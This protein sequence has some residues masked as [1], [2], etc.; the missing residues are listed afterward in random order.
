MNGKKQRSESDEIEQRLRI[1]ALELQLRSY[2]R[3]LSKSHSWREWLTAAAPA[4]AFVGLA[5]TVSWAIIQNNQA[6]RLRIE[7]DRAQRFEAAVNRLGSHDAN[8][9]LTG[10]TG[11]ET[12][13][14]DARFHATAWNS[15][16][17]AIAVED[18]AVVRASLLESIHSLPASQEMKNDGL[19]TLIRLNSSLTQSLVAP[20]L[21]E[22][23]LPIEPLTHSE[24]LLAMKDAVITLLERGA[25]ATNFDGIYCVRCDFRSLSGGDHISYRAAIIDDADFSGVTLTSADFSYASLVGTNFDHAILHHA[26][27]DSAN[28]NPFFW[29][30]SFGDDPDDPGPNFYCADLTGSSFD[31][32]VV[33]G[34]KISKGKNGWW[35]SPLRSAGMNWFGTNIAGTTFHNLTAYFASTEGKIVTPEIDDNSQ[36]RFR[37]V[38]GKERWIGFKL[39]HGRDHPHLHEGPLDQWD[40]VTWRTFGL[41]LDTTSANLPQKMR[42]AIGST[43]SNPGLRQ[44][45]QQK[46]SER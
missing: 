44:Q 42:I 5:F 32:F 15:L 3:D 2:E 39:V 12:F 25:K 17:Q 40:D 1:K 28:D 27:F 46:C 23:Q 7:E 6:K 19:K 43:S 16:V 31:G 18:D 45:L 10:L 24:R 11:L 8:S 36:L 41:V 20:A 4:I 30:Q 29:Y 26:D 9:R 35:P 38:R 37:D 22:Q 34:Y 21:S 13:I 33:E 14:Q